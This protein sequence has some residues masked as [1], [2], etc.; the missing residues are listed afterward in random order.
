MKHL[1]EITFIIGA[2]MLLALVVYLSHQ[3]DTCPHADQSTFA[4]AMK[5]GGATCNK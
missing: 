2:A 1:P 3:K 4:T 5:V